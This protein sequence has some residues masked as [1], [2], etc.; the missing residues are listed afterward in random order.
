MN[1]CCGFII[2]YIPSYYVIIILHK[3]HNSSLVAASGVAE[4]E[5]DL[6]YTYEEGENPE[7]FFLPYLWENA[8]R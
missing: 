1:L 3:L 7:D 5:V 6:T 4:G 8:V 2:H